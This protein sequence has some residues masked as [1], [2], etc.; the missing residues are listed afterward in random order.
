MICIFSYIL[1]R[2]TAENKLEFLVLKFKGY[3][4]ALMTFQLVEKEP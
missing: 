4:S 1:H 3:I 2:V